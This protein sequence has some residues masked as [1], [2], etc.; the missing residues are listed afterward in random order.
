MKSRVEL[1]QDLDELAAWVPAMLA[2]TDAA[3][4]MDAFAG[5]AELI[6]DAARPRQGASCERSPRDKA[7]I[8]PGAGI[9][10]LVG[11]LGRHALRLVIR[12]IIAVLHGGNRDDLLRAGQF[13]KRDIG[14]AHEADLP[15]LA[16]LRQFTH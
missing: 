4:Q 9:D 15:F 11:L 6:E 8:L 14:E 3:S 5:R 13:A 10:H 12:K 2:E 1:D 16:H 7:D